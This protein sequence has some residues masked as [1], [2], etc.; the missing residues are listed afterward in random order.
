MKCK[1]YI[2]A[3]TGLSW[4]VQPERLGQDEHI[5]NKIFFNWALQYS[6]QMKKIPNTS[7]VTDLEI[8]TAT[9]K[10]REKQWEQSGISEFICENRWRT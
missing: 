1:S 2:G 10:S 3:Q 5:E 4:D 6:S 8:C 7:C 9:G